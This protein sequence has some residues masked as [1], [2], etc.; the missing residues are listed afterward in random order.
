MEKVENP[1]VYRIAS[2]VYVSMEAVIVVV[3]VIIVT[4]AVALV[5]LLMQF[6]EALYKNCYTKLAGTV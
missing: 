5:A 1:R 4:V 6:H 2:V 3:V